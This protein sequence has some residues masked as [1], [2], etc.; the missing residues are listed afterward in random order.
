MNVQEEE[1]QTQQHNIWGPRISTRHSNIR[2]NEMLERYYERYDK[3]H[4][5]MVAYEEERNLYFCLQLVISNKGSAPASNIDLYL[6]LP[7]GV[8]AVDKLPKKP[9]C[10]PPPDQHWHNSMG[11]EHFP[12]F[13]NLVNSNNGKPRIKNNGSVVRIS[14]GKL[15]HEFNCTCDYITLRFQDWQSVKSFGMQFSISA[16]EMPEA[17]EGT[18]HVIARLQ[19][20]QAEHPQKIGG[21]G[22]HT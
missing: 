7:E 14:V 13:A 8:E 4:A 22:D 19:D 1:L 21:D 16:N 2:H 15:K 12:N 9:K 3:Y 18:I 10:P 11:I 17:T 6:H 5:D 20:T